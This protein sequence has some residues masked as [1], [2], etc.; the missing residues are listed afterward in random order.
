MERRKALAM[1]VMIFYKDKK[2]TAAAAQDVMQVLADVTARELQAKMEVRVV[3][4]VMSLNANAVHIEM[5]FRDFNEWTDETLQS[6]HEKMMAKIGE[7]LSSHD[8]H[9]QYSFYI[10]PSMPPRSIWSQGKV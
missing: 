5:R 4:P 3:E 10:V 9:G 2:V 8:F 1:P 6:Y 7:A